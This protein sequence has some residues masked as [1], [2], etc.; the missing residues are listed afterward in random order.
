MNRMMILLGLLVALLLLSACGDEDNNLTSIPD[1]TNQG[2]DWDITVVD[3][4]DANTK[5]TSYWVHCEW[6]GAESSIV[7]TDVFSI[8]FDNQSYNLA[9]GLY[10]GIWSFSTEAMLNSG[11]TYAVEFYK[12]GT[13]IAN[14]ALKI[15]HRANANF[16]TT[17]DPA[18]PASLTWSLDQSNPFQAISVY[19]YNPDT[20]DSSDAEM[21]ISSSARSYTIPAQTIESFGANGEYDITLMQA[22]F[23]KVGRYA[24]TSISGTM[25][26]YGV[27][28]TKEAY[29][30]KMQKMA[31]QLR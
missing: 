11:T 3:L 4:A 10:F 31:K 2:F 8:K 1:I 30:A 22:D 25:M 28:P 6:L 15:P 12:N 14:S 5:E 17:F 16:P 20:D 9:G 27:T 23:H 13:K 7:A 24:F 26:Q 19:G 29:I 18:L 21:F